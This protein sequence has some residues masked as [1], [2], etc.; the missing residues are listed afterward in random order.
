MARNRKGWPMEQTKIA[1]QTTEFV[2]LMQR[3]QSLV[4]RSSANAMAKATGK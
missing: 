2:D 3:A 1:E 4:Q